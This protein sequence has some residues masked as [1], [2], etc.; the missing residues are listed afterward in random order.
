MDAY[1]VLYKG[2]S[3][4]RPDSWSFS[5]LHWCNGIDKSFCIMDQFP[6]ALILPLLLLTSSTKR[7]LWSTNRALPGP[8]CSWGNRTGNNSILTPAVPSTSWREASSPIGTR[9]WN[10]S[11]WPKRT[12]VSRRWLCCTSGTSVVVPWAKLRNPASSITGPSGHR[13]RKGMPTSM[14][15]TPRSFQKLDD[16]LQTCQAHDL[17]L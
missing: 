2:W 11:W 8:A 17:P 13:I 14:A 12:L 4:N 6:L 5:S 16:S 10:R 7:C 9:G 1:R 15:E 3:V